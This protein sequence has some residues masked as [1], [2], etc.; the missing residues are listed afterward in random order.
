ML[1]VASGQ[2]AGGIA[3]VALPSREAYALPARATAVMTEVVVPR[4]AQVLAT[5][6]VIMRHASHPVLVHHL[7]MGA[8]VLVLGPIWPDVQ[9]LLRSQPG[10]QHFLARVLCRVVCVVISLH[11]QRECALFDD[12]VSRLQGGAVHSRLCCISV[13]VVA[14]VRLET[15]VAHIHTLSFFPALVARTTSEKKDGLRTESHFTI[16]TENTLLRFF[17]RLTLPSER[18]H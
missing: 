7:R 1:L 18:C 14:R 9:P 15:L 13:R 10:Y 3:V 16:I 6:P 11:Y 17:L 2:A 12:H 8:P 4:P 5:L